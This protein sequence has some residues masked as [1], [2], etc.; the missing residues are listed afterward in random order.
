MAHIETARGAVEFFDPRTAHLFE[1]R[2][3]HLLALIQQRSPAVRGLALHVAAVMASRGMRRAEV[4]RLVQ[5]GLDEGRYLREVGSESPVLAHAPGALITMDELDAA[6]RWSRRCPTTRTARIG[7]RLR[8][9]LHLPRL[10]QSAARDPDRRRGAS[11]VWGG[12]LREHGLTF[13]LPSA[14]QCGAD[15]LLERPSVD[16][17]A[18]L[19]ES[20]TL[21]ASL[22]ATISGAFVLAVRG[23]LRLARGQRPEAIA[24]LRRA[25]GIALGARVINPLW[26]LWHWPPLALALPREQLDE[27]MELAEDELAFARRSGLARCEGVAL[28]TSGCLQGGRRGIELLE[29]SL[30]VLETTEAV[31]E[32]ARTLVELGAALRRSGDHR[33]AAGEHL[34]AGFHLADGYGAERLAARVEDELRASGARP[35]RRAVARP[36]AGQARASP[37]SRPRI[38]EPRDTPSPSS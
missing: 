11:P 19:V 32:R 13:W 17:I 29:A 36:R 28:R 16:D 8:R 37:A 25:G 7:R 18:Q 15:I 23:R 26:L 22:A 24:D 2:L 12:S 38:D 3:P 35:R 34:Y 14:F 10:D 31:L 5:Q 6:A 21:P 1:E 9:R 30:D 33:V 4:L 20:L 27:A